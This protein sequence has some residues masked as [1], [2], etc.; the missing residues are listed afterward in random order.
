VE[1]ERASTNLMARFVATPVLKSRAQ[2][3][4]L[5]E[6]CPETEAGPALD[7]NS[8]FITK[9]TKLNFETAIMQDSIP[10]QQEKNCA[11]DMENKGETMDICDEQSNITE[12]ANVPLSNSENVTAFIYEEMDRRVAQLKAL[13][14]PERK[15]ILGIDNATT[16]ISM[17]TPLKN[18]VSVNQTS[19]SSVNRFT[20][21]HEKAFSKMPSIATHYTIQKTKKVETQD[22]VNRKRKDPDN[23][24]PSF[25]K[26]KLAHS[27]QDSQATRTSKDIYEKVEEDKEVVKPTVKK[28]YDRN[29]TMINNR[30]SIRLNLAK[31]KN[32]SQAEIQQST[33]TSSRFNI[34]ES[35]KKRLSY[36]PHKGPVKSIIPNPDGQRKKERE[37]LEKRKQAARNGMSY[38]IRLLLLLL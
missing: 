19:S 23:V 5:P 7:K 31:S 16:E 17:A 13:P 20:Q 3:N 18:N 1:T 37:E 26:Q 11:K 6:N 14:S 33:R 2:T 8:P 15:K 12:I 32:V 29:R 34:Q 30:S 9:E 35:L 21:V 4:S 27:T 38:Y 28:T 22:E 36:V 25:K 10:I 24:H